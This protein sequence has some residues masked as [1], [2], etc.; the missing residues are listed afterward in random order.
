MFLPYLQSKIKSMQNI[1]IAIDGH[2]STGKSTFA[3]L[4]AER[5]GFEFVDSGA[6]YRAVTLFAIDNGYIE[7]EEPLPQ[8]QEAL[9]DISI[10][11]RTINSTERE[12]C[13]NGKSIEAQIRGLLVSDLV[14]PIST[15]GYVRDFVNK[16]L[17]KEVVG[18]DV[19]VDGRDIGTVVFPEAQL[20]I[21]MTAEPVIRAQRRLEQLL[22]K[23]IEADF[24]TIY[25]NVTE[26]DYRDSHREIAPLRK[27]EDAVV[28]D[29]SHLTIDEQ[30]SFM[31]RLLNERFGL[32]LLK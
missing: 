25:N 1:I 5:L 10:S 22:K 32:S 7:G 3:K 31:E 17:R 15:I 9:K 8:L 13:L 18:K 27:G 26:R 4:I 30:I 2:S 14:S 12:I 6:V 16:F 11:L 20:K 19:V 24:E 28:L 29:N 23:G 21:F